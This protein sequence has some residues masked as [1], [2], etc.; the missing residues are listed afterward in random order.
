MHVCS[1]CGYG[2]AS[3]LGRCPGCGEW[4]T[5]KKMQDT[6]DGSN[7]KTSDT[8]KTVSLSSFGKGDMTRY[9]SGIHEFDRVLGGGFVKGAVVLL[10]G[11]PGI[12]KSTLIL[13]AMQ[14][15][16]TLYVSGEEGGEQI[17][18]RADRLGVDHGKFIF[19]NTLQLE[20]LEDGIR[21]RKN[22]FEIIVIDSIQ[23]LYSNRIESQPGSIAQIRELTYRLVQL[24]KEL[25][26]PMV[27]VGHVTKG[28]DVSGPKTLE[29][30]VDA[31][32]LFEGERISQYRILRNQ[33][34]RFASTDEIGIFQMAGGGLEEITE[35]IAFVGEV[36][37][38]VPGKAVAG[39][40]DGNRPLFFEIQALTVPTSLP[41]PRRVV[42][43]IDYN[44]LLLLLAVMRKHLNLSFDAM[45]IY[46]N[47]VGGLEVRSPAA[48]M[49]IMAALISSM[50]NLRLPEKT[51]FVGEVGL[52]GEIRSVPHQKR[53]ASESKRLQFTSVIS[54]HDTKDVKQ[55]MKRLIAK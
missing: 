50:K 34:N 44:K 23:T 37:V 25:R 18:G 11:E 31:V 38:S 16:R 22:E 20:A 21:E 5:F 28:G 14:N 48:D 3:W 30:I 32:L 10:T 39:I 27:I 53:I 36:D 1:N 41:V 33:K 29:H 52:L 35:S 15:F 8:M 4:N 49:G 43:G 54:S 42:K 40:I 7:R 13:Q 46:V 45:D 47:V 24:A 26:I 19:T 55:L 2:S 9:P 17:K 6:P 51:I 12:G